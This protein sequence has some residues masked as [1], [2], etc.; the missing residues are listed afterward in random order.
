MLAMLVE[1]I[2]A[3]RSTVCHALIARKSWE[4]TAGGLERE[5]PVGKVESRRG[6]LS[7]MDRSGLA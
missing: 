3:M 7:G 5:D 6:H 1:A 4:M 2:F